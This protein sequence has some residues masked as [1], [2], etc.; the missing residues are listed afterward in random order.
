MRTLIDEPRVTK[1]C[2]EVKATSSEL[3]KFRLVETKQQT[4]PTIPPRDCRLAN[5]A[6]KAGTT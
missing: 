4:G 6:R 5:H 3:D 1:A 2:G